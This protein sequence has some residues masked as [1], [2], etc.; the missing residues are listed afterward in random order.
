MPTL[1]RQ[2]LKRPKEGGCCN[3]KAEPARSRWKRAARS[4]SVS[5]QGVLR[6]SRSGAGGLR[7]S[8]PGDGCEREADRVADAVMRM[9]ADSDPLAVR[10]SGAMLDVWR[11]CAECEQ[12]QEDQE[13]SLHPKSRHDSGPETDSGFR[14]RLDSQRGGGE[15]LPESERAFFE[16]RFGRDFGPIRLMRE[17]SFGS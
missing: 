10:H 16:P 6:A 7:V 3:S 13:Q 1:E 2:S 14:A 5:N 17:S 15:P 9:P 12:E 8:R 4:G 11:M